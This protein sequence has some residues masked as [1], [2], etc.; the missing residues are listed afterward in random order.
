MTAKTAK[1]T[2]R[3]PLENKDAKWINLEKITYQDERGNQRSWE[4]TRRTT[5][6]KG[7]TV[8][9]IQI[10]AILEKATGPELLLEKQFRPPVDKIVIEL[11][12]GLVD[13]GESPEQAAVRE[14]LEE[15]GYVGTVIQDRGGGA[16]PV[17]HSSPAS[18]SSCNYVIHVKID[19]NDP[20]NQKPKA[21]LEEGEFI[22]VFSVPLRD[23]Y[24]ECRA[25]EA[26]GYAI[27]GKLGTFAEGLEMSKMWQV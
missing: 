7:S 6:P 11:P 5:K 17:L 22:E 14:L 20:E 21:K 15:T 26:Q 24:M 3:E 27:D 1:V 25:L 12:A 13:A 8:D 4:G 23:L 9:A 10:V 19:L 2:G 16:R 18:S